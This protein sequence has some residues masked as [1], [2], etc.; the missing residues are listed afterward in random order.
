MK[1]NLFKTVY[2]VFLAM[3]CFS[4][5]AIVFTNNTTIGSGDT[6]YEGM[7]IVVSNCVLTVDGEH[8][9]SSVRIANSGILTH[10]I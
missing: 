4:V 5:Q 2:C 6:N 10:S 7:D 8:S 3:Q 1:A 9:F